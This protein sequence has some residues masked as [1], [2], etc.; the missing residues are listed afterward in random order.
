M[1]GAFL[2]KQSDGEEEEEELEQGRG[3]MDALHEQLNSGLW[4]VIAYCVVIA[5]N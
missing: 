4:V 2:Q 5:G 1:M 3:S